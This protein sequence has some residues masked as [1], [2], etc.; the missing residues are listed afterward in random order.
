MHTNRFD[1]ELRGFVRLSYEKCVL[2][3]LVNEFIAT[4]TDTV[5]EKSYFMP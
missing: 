3:H 4:K 2:F 1:T 5:H